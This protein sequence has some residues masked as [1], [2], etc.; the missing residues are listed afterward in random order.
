VRNAAERVLDFRRMRFFWVIIAASVCVWPNFAG[1]EE[2]LAKIDRSRVVGTPVLDQAPRGIHVWLEDGWYRIAA[3]SAL[4]VGGKKTMKRDL[5]IT[6]HSTKTITKVELDEW[7]RS[8]GGSESLVLR[9]QAGPDPE[10]MR[11]QTEGELL[12]SNATFEGKS[13]PIYLGPL[14]RLGQNI[15]RIGRY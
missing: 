15:V 2:K 9:V 5:T 1:A 10:I 14:S 6:V 7:K 12:I 4:P 11:F 13:T 8:G 3:I